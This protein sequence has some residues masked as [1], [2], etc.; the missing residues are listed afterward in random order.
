ME[1]AYFAD[2]KF[3]C[4][5]S[6]FVYTFCRLL[7][8]SQKLNRTFIDFQNTQSD[9][10]VTKELFKYGLFW[11]LL[12]NFGFHRSQCK[13][14]VIYG[15]MTLVYYMYTL[16]QNQIHVFTGNA[17]VLHFMVFSLSKIVIYGVVSLTFFHVYI[18]H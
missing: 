16:F 7:D 10:S 14:Q 17:Q 5:L 6:F 8:F 9:H 15:N 11:K 18:C 3:S 12:K 13:M 1:G 2:G 4:H